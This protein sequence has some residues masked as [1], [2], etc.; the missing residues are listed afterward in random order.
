MCKYFG[1]LTVCLLVVGCGESDVDGP[2]A[3]G[4]RHFHSGNFQQ[5]VATLTE[6]IND[7]PADVE[8]FLLRG[9]AKLCLGSENAGTAI[10][11]FNEAI[12]LD[13]N[14]YEAYYQRAIA[15][16]ERGN[17]K[18]AALDEQKARQL[19]PIAA[20]FSRRTGTAPLEGEEEAEDEF[21]D[22]PELADLPGKS[23]TPILDSEPEF[24][25]DGNLVPRDKSAMD[26]VDEEGYPLEGNIPIPGRGGRSTAAND[27]ATR[28]GGGGQSRLSSD[29]GVPTA[30]KDER[31]SSESSRVG[32]FTEEL[33]GGRPR[34][35]GSRGGALGAGGLTRGNTPPP[36]ADWRS[37]P[38]PPASPLSPGEQSFRKPSPVGTL[39][40]GNPYSGRANSPIGQ[41]DQNFN[42]YLPNQPRST[43]F[44]PSRAYRNSAGAGGYNSGYSPYNSPVVPRVEAPIR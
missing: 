25:E 17:R 12:R 27:A 9:Q 23:N 6:A 2:L 37:T 30:D 42:P 1:L 39:P 22:L 43:G 44:G 31:S 19:D 34:E 8:A 29:N 4:K 15:H 36:L 40:F 35:E 38:T 41:V 26:I 28:G 20:K 10:A 18:L 11:D 21:A 7:N 24:D 33:F 5:A 32:S 16:R 14:N 3:K 13:P